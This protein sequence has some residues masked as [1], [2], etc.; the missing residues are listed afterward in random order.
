MKQESSGFNRDRFKKI[1]IVEDESGLNRGISFALMQEGYETVSAENK[2]TGWELFKKEHP[3]AV[4]LDLNLPDGDGIELCRIIRRVSEI[5]LL[6]L[7]ARDMEVDEIMGLE[8]GADDYITKPFSVTVLK[9]RLEKALKKYEGKTSK[10]MQKPEL[11]SGPVR[12]NPNTARAYLN[13]K[14]LELSLTEFR[15][16]QYFLENKNQVLLK[17]Q[18]LQHIWDKG[19]KFVEENTLTVNISRLRRKIGGNVIKTVYGMGYLWEE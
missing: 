4:L 9:L 10:G 2:E 7:T 16:L 6:I 13:E 1:L 14:E 15:L 18:I 5:P 8:S 17:E 3:D 12:L 19:Q 11:W